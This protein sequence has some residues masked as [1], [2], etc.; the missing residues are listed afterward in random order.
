MSYTA[1]AEVIVG[2]DTHKHVHVAVNALV[3]GPARAEACRGGPGDMRV[4]LSPAP[5][6]LMMAWNGPPALKRTVA[7]RCLHT[8]EAAPP[9]RRRSWRDR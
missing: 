2:V 7:V 4:G 5:L 6:L 9:A 1:P 8:G 3:A